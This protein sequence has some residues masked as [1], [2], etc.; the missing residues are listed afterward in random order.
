MTVELL[1][2]RNDN[3]LQVGRLAADESC[4]LTDV[5]VVQSCVDLIQHEEWS[6][7]IAKNDASQLKIGTNTFGE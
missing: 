1:F 6:R 7:L 4:N 5:G 3:R 2:E